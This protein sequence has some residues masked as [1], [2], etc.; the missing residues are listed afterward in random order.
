MVFDTPEQKKLQS[1]TPCLANKHLIWKPLM[2]VLPLDVTLMKS[3]TSFL[4]SSPRQRAVAMAAHGFIAEF[5]G[6]GWASQFERL[7][8]YFEA[9]GIF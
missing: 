5:T 7:N 9:N 1:G 4:Q 3:S 2:P 8:L 6:I